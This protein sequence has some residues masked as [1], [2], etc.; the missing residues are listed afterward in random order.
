M[1]YDITTTRLTSSEKE[2]AGGRPPARGFRVK[3]IEVRPAGVSGGSRSPGHL[4]I[5]RHGRR[6]SSGIMFMLP[7]FSYISLEKEPPVEKVRQILPG[8][9][10]GH[11]DEILRRGHLK[12]VP[13]IIG[14]QD[15]QNLLLPDLIHQLP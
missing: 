5:R 1:L 7:R 3:G 4:R 10:I 2:K 9:L 6:A 15:F 14:P 11:P 8:H 12:L 13:V